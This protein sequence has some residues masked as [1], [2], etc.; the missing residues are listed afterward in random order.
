VLDLKQSMRETRATVFRAVIL[1]AI[2]SPS[3]SDEGGLRAS[4]QLASRRHATYGAAGHSKADMAN[5]RRLARAHALDS[6][7][8]LHGKEK[9]STKSNSHAT[10]HALAPSRLNARHTGMRGTLHRCHFEGDPDHLE[11]YLL[12]TQMVNPDEFYY[13]RDRRRHYLEHLFTEDE[14]TNGLPSG[15][16]LS[17]LHQAESCGP[18]GGWSVLA[19]DEKDGPGI[20]WHNTAPCLPNEGRS[21]AANITVDYFC[22]APLERAYLHRCLSDELPTEGT[23]ETTAAAGRKYGPKQGAEQGTRE[24]IFDPSECFNGIPAWS[25]PEQPQSPCLASLRWTEHCT[26]DHDWEVLRPDAP[27]RAAGSTASTHDGE[28]SDVTDPQGQQSGIAG[29]RWFSSHACDCSKVG[30]DFFCPGGAAFAR[31]LHR[32]AFEGPSDLV[33]DDPRCFKNHGVAALRDIDPGAGF[34]QGVGLA[35]R[36]EHGS[37]RRHVFAAEECQGGLPRGRCLASL[38]RAQECGAEQDFRALAPGEEDGVV[39]GVQWYNG[40]D[41]PSPCGHAA[42]AVDYLCF[43]PGEGETDAEDEVAAW[44]DTYALSH[45]ILSVEKDPH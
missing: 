30:A 19:P 1:I 39:A 27:S 43:P 33:A 34:V 28:A 37:C 14:C 38:T 23:E 17:A 20:L 24:R 3:V 7:S 15:E 25:S 4:V 16:C 22:P 12:A 8:Q 29:V 2:F 44:A 42:V 41:A 40:L 11:D 10:S 35:P 13:G 45:P 6:A 5:S 26:D 21:P 32:C 36:Q 9:A 31:S 18:D